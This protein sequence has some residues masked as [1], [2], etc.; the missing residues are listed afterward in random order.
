MPGVKR[1]RTSNNASRRPRKKRK[2]QRKN[3]IN[4]SFSNNFKS[5]TSFQDN[6]T[7]L[8]SRKR[9]KLKYGESVHLNIMG[10]QN[11]DFRMNSLHDPDKTVTGHQPMAYDQWSA[12]YNRYRVHAIKL[13]VTCVQGDNAEGASAM[14]A[15]FPN[16]ADVT[17]TSNYQVLE[18]QNSAYTF[19]GNTS[20]GQSISKLELYL[21]IKKVMGLNELDDDYTAAVG[22]N[23]V[24][25]PVVTLWAENMAGISM[26]IQAVVEITYYAEFYEPKLLGLS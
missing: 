13:E 18:M 6:N 20:A 19:I 17:V 11:H 16:P 7:G 4:P 26:D 2:V 23:P 3:F 21:D 5:V 14:I 9:V 10:A 15:L 12:L 22:A 1:K 8:P 24:K 25:S